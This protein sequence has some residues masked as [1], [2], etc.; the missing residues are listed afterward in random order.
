MGNMP[1]SANLFYRIGVWKA[2]RLAKKL[3][4]AKQ[5]RKAV[6]L[7]LEQLRQLRNNEQD[8]T[9]EDTIEKYEDMVNRL[10]K[11]VTDMESM[12]A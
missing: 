2:N 3:N 9:L 8:P 7:R 4:R 1:D 6:E 10:A 11:E 5:E 12:Y